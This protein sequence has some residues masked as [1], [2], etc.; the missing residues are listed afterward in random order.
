MLQL[1]A[2]TACHLAHRMNVSHSAHSNKCA[3]VAVESHKR[4]LSD[5]ITTLQVGITEWV[6]GNETKY[7][8][9]NKTNRFR[10]VDNLSG[11][12]KL[13]SNLVENTKSPLQRQ[14]I[15]KGTVCKVTVWR[16]SYVP[17]MVGVNKKNDISL[18]NNGVGIGLGYHRRARQRALNRKLQSVK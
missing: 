1:S 11:I 4:Q 8:T 13:P 6:S 15:H 12:Y 5:K 2:A 18:T 9:W 3:G 14:I 16:R 10:Y 7:W 17:E